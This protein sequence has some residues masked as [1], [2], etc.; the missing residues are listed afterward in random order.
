MADS[1]LSKKRI[2]S[3][4]E[5]DK[6]HKKLCLDYHDKET[7]TDG[8][9][10]AMEDP[11]ASTSQPTKSHGLKKRPKKNK[12][13]RELPLPELCSAADVLY[14]E[15]RSLLGG[16]VVDGVTSEGGAFKSPY[17]QGDEVELT[18]DRMTAGGKFKFSSM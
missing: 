5:A 16:G 12:K 17:S 15:I 18:I 1:S 8:A 7:N 4:P 14:E 9:N 3:E 13:R 11:I 6:A 10:S 2:L